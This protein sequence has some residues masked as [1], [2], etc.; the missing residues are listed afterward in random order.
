VLASVA[1]EMAVVAVDRGSPTSLHRS[2]VE[3]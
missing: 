3:P 1:G 2:A